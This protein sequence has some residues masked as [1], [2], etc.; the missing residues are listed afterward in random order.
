MTPVQSSRSMRMRLAL[1]LVIS[2]LMLVL[3]IVAGTL[4]LNNWSA[5]GE[6]SSSAASVIFVDEDGKCHLLSPSCA[7]F[8]TVST[9]W[10]T[11]DTSVTATPDMALR[12]I[13]PATGTTPTEPLLLP[14]LTP[15]RAV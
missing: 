1:A 4:F 15:P 10:L 9:V 13:T 7:E 5:H 8:L 3:A 2:S 12:A 14:P 6:P 11:G